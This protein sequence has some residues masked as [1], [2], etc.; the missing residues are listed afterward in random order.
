M[1]KEIIKPTLQLC[2]V[3]LISACSSNGVGNNDKLSAD[4]LLKSA[5]TYFSAGDDSMALVMLDSLDHSLPD[6]I[7]Q[8]K[9]ARLLRPQAVERF[10][11]SRM[12]M[13]DS[14]LVVNQIRGEQLRAGLE[15]VSGT[16]V[17]GYFVGRG[18]RGVDV[19][20]T[21]G[22]HSRL[23]PDYHFYLIASSPQAVGSVAIELQ[24]GDDRVTSATVNYDGERN[25]RNSACE[26]I[27][28]TE[29]ESYPIGEFV[30]R[31]ENDPIEISFIGSGGRR[32]SMALS[33]G[34]RKA[35]LSAFQ[36]IEAVNADRHYRLEKDRLQRQVDIARKQLANVAAK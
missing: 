35:L 20:A 33:P 17:E 5:Q 10:A 25:T 19:R 2:C 22:L 11:M 27:T 28:F 1:F 29:A 3:A 34:Q 6:A 32:S 8:R 12:S 30:A 24:S 18:T 9:E 26:S 7:D 4:S 14:L 13:A 15:F 36:M 23:S 21:A 31:H 16:G